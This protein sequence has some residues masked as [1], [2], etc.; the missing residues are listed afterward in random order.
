WSRG[1]NPLTRIVVTGIDDSYQEH[2]EIR[3]AFQRCLLTDD[4]IATRGSAWEESWDGLE[5]WL[6]PIHDVA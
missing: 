2:E 3:A 5:P 6:G 1:Q 4:E